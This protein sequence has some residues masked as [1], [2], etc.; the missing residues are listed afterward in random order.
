[1]QVLIKQ[2]AAGE[3]AMSHLVSLVRPGEPIQYGPHWA[4][5]T[6]VQS[7]KFEVL[8]GDAGSDTPT[9]TETVSTPVEA[10]LMVLEHLIALARE[11]KPEE[12][13]KPPPEKPGG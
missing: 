6:K 10:K 13:P 12:E 3:L 11:T 7:G 9:S 8:F 1:M 2:V 5:Y 4:R